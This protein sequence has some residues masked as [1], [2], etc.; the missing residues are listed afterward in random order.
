MRG[1]GYHLEFKVGQPCLVQFESTG[2]KYKS[3]IIGVEQ[4]AFVI[5]KLPLVPGIQKHMNAGNPVLV[6]M[7]QGGT[8][9]GFS[10]E[11]LSHSLRPVPFVVFAYPPRVEGVQYREHK[12][13]LCMLPAAVSNPYFTTSGLVSDISMGGCRLMVE[14]RDKP[15]VFNMMTGDKLELRLHL[16]SDDTGPVEATLMNYK[17]LK[18][19]YTMGLKFS[20]EERLKSLAHYI[21]R[22]EGAWAAVQGA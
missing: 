20:G 5:A 1:P 17:E 22:L 9:Y 4:Y 7:E 14:W 6:R 3:V 2:Q 13:T 16:D 15:K 11:I 8:V 19:H 18:R 21:G 12:R 10:T